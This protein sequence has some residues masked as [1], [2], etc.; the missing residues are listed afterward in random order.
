MACAEIISAGRTFYVS[1]LFL[2]LKLSQGTCLM[3][4][5]EKQTAFLPRFHLKVPAPQNPS[6]SHPG[7]AGDSSTSAS[8][9]FGVR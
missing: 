5:Q 4:R 2:T 7:Q 9:K 1:A 6:G 3:A 8:L